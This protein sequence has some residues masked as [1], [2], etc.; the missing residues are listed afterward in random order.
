VVI[1]TSRAR[2]EA[3]RIFARIVAHTHRRSADITVSGSIP[4]DAR[5]GPFV[6]KTRQKP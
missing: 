3:P 5:A 1:G 6:A 4:R 2:V